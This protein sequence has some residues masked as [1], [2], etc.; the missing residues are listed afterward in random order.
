M[1]NMHKTI[2][3]KRLLDKANH[4]L[5]ESADNRSEFREGV[6]TMIESILMDTGNY[7][8]FGYL[9]KEELK[10]RAKTPGIQETEDHFEIVDETRRHYFPSVLMQD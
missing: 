7:R 3:V 10:G 8:G 9:S 2:K 6:A 5:A 1:S 4:M